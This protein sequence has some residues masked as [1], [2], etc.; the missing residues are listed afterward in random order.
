MKT[1]IKLIFACLLAAAVSACSTLTTV[2]EA[3]GEG[4][5]H[6]YAASKDKIWA[7]VPGIIEELGL[8]L[9]RTEPENHV[10]LARHDATLVSYGEHVAVF[11]RPR[12]DGRTEV[13][14][15]SEPTLATTFAA[16]DWTDE[17]FAELDK[18]FE[19]RPLGASG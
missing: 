14:V 10:F 9:M 1:G 18:R 2:K 13:E 7:A 8:D 6:V 3:E 17:V 11:V 19:R 15:V 12:S 5:V 4:T 16:E